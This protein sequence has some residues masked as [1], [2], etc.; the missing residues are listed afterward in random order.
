[1]LFLEVLAGFAIDRLWSSASSLRRFAWFAG[2]AD[3]AQQRT[4]GRGRAGVL[5]VTLP[6]VLGVSLVHYLLSE[7]L[8]VLAFI[9]DVVVLLYC[10][11]P[12][13]LDAQVRAFIQASVRGDETGAH[14]YM[15]ALAYPSAGA[16]MES[17]PAQL[18]AP[19][20]MRTVIEA[21]LV[22]ANERWFAVIFWFFV[23]GPMGAVFYRLS[24]LL[25][26]PVKKTAE[27]PSIDEPDSFAAAAHHLHGILGWVPA[28]ITAL[29]YAVMGSF[30]DAIDSWNRS[31]HQVE[32]PS[33]A[34]AGDRQGW[35]RVTEMHRSRDDPFMNR[36]SGNAQVLVASGLGALRM[37]VEEPGTT[38]QPVGISHVRDALALVW[39][40][41]VLCIITLALVTVGGWLI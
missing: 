20:M 5:L 14:R 37:D 28:R 39:R 13:D 26:A 34:S 25:A 9:F 11:G 31:I 32:F 18:T 38:Q 7:L 1:M 10:L 24:S 27:D 36:P 17:C 40:T 22:Q 12:K 41:V 16:A 8:L 3:W 21:T 33:A 2:F 30:V 23:L 29:S 19:Q 15:A 4:G 35:R 6:L